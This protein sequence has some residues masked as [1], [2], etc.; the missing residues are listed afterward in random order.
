[1]DDFRNKF[2]EMFSNRGQTQSMDMGD[3]AFGNVDDENQ[4]PGGN[5]GGMAYID[6][7]GTIDITN[8]VQVLNPTRPGSS[9]HVISFR[10][11]NPARPES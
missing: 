4:P 10:A 6:D 11:C 1:M 2:L 8:T 5:V 3:A 7:D 9:N